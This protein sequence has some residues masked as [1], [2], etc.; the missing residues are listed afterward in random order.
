[1]NFFIR[2]FHHTHKPT[3]IDSE[4]NK[5]WLNSKCE[6][7]GENIMIHKGVNKERWITESDNLKEML[8]GF[9]D[10]FDTLLGGILMM[11]AIIL[12]ALVLFGSRN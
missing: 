10:S 6:I 5:Y 9:D 4:S 11:I 3:I 12:W 8:S 2:L 1:M 7:C